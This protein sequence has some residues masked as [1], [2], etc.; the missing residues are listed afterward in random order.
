MTSL[1]PVY[2]EKNNCQ[3]CYKC[4]RECPV[5]AIK[6]DK[7]RASVVPEL[8]TFCGRC[9]EICPAKAKKVRN[10]LWKAQKIVETS[11]KVAVSI[12]PSYISE[13]SNVSKDKFIAALK[14][15]G[16][17]Y[18]SETALGA[19]KVSEYTTE[20][21]EKS[22][23]KLHI[24][25]ACPAV[26]EL[27]E[28]FYPKLVDS[29]VP[30]SSPLIAHAKY[31]KNRLGDNTPVIF[32]GP[33]IA[34]KRESDN[35][36]GL[37]DVAITFDDLRI[38]FN[39]EQ[40]E[41]D[42]I[43]SAT[44]DDN[45]FFPFESGLATLYPTDGGMI[46]SINNYNANTGIT[47]MNFSGLNRIQETL[48]DISKYNISE[49]IFLEL[50]ACSGGCING[51]G[52][53]EK[54]P[55]AIKNMSIISET[56]NRDKNCYIDINSS[57]LD[58]NYRSRKTHIPEYSLSEY[59]EALQLVGKYSEKDELNCGGCGYDSCKDF[60]HAI[61]ECRAERSMCA[62][63]MR[64]VAHNKASV[65]LQKI[66]SGVVMVDENLMVI[67]TNKSFAKILGD[68]I[69]MIF[70]AN[71]GMR[72]A[73]LQKL[74]SFHKQFSSILASGTE[75]Y[76][77]D[78]KHNGKLLHLSLFTIQPNKIVG[79]VVRDLTMPEIRRDEVIKRTKTVIKENL[80]TVQRIAYLLGENASKTEAILNSIVES[81]NTDE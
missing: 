62:S 71:P 13:W 25:S 57:E 47:L 75:N 8:C 36:L 58:I 15:L 74:V 22:S 21:I 11:D 66:P 37:I 18:I 53:S 73:N 12:A 49:K 40:I 56:R 45:N 4:I 42:E 52:T 29:I 60:A 1:L 70:E 23:N 69:M 5:K 54:L 43:K 80:N 50:L 32:I 9:T 68:E 2:T 81:H 28:K 14:L 76:E 19:E 67:E 38:W 51:P 46:K 77:T 44:D 59:R 35:N 79:G 30:I 55:H 27:I 7:G 64:G 3:D 10:D 24:S 72:G 65:L 31:L 26:V 78:V 16:F 61:L 34:K 17:T 63:Y 20:Y 48:K 6:V 33:C 39:Q 41:F